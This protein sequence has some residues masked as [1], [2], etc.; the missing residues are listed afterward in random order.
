M[1]RP[2]KSIKQKEPVRLR[3]RK[4]SDGKQSLYLDIYFKGQRSY[5]NLSLYLLPETSLLAKSHNAETLEKAEAIRKEKILELTNKAAGIRDRSHKSHIPYIEWLKVYEQY[6]ADKGST[7]GVKWIRKVQNDVEA[8]DPQTL[9][10]DIDKDYIM[11]YLKHLRERKAHTGKERNLAPRTIALHMSY[12]RS[13]LS[14]AVQQ[15]VL[16]ANPYRGIST[17][18]LRQKETRREYLTIDEVKTLINAPCEREDFKQAFLFACFCGFRL[19][20][21]MALRWQDISCDGGKWRAGIRQTKTKQLVYVPLGQMAQKFM[22][23][24]DTEHPESQVFPKLR[25]DSN[26]IIPR[27]AKSAGIKKHVSF[28]TSRHTFATMLLTTGT[29]IY[30]TGH[31]LGHADIRKTLIYAKIVNAKKLAAVNSIDEAFEIQQTNLNNNETN[32]EK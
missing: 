26:S 18:D 6:L 31:L 29:D 24:R 20:D 4:L 21:V 8:Y 12:I 14:Y 13:S 10:C 9:L 3:S 16:H 25:L 22:P 11:G 5:Q 7:G 1:G 32:E 28:H 19:S 15:D 17:E 23:E 27:W 30:T 2:K